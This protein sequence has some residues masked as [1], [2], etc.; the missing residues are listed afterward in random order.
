MAA[1]REQWVH[2]VRQGRDAHMRQHQ[3][4]QEH[5]ERFQAHQRHR[6][7]I[8]RAHA[9]HKADEDWKAANCKLCPNCRRAINKLE[10][11]DLMKCGGDY[12]G[13]NTQNGCGASFN[14]SQAPPYQGE[15]L[16]GIRR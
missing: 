8:L 14:W 13:G 7:E 12:H 4:H 2:W 16:G 3:A 6:D 11:C 1:R 15:N 5:V 10:G 9:T